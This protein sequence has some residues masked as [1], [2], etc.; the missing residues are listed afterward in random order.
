M[1]GSP[2]NIHSTRERAPRKE[3]ANNKGSRDKPNRFRSAS[4]NSGKWS[5]DDEEFIAS[6]SIQDESTFGDR[7]VPRPTTGRSQQAKTV[8][9]HQPQQQ[10]FFVTSPPTLRE[11]KRNELKNKETFDF[12]SPVS[13]PKPTTYRPIETRWNVNNV[14]THPTAVTT[15]ATEATVSVKYQDQPKNFNSEQDYSI[16]S[17]KDQDSISSII[18]NSQQRNN[19]D[20]FKVEQKSVNSPLFPP[21]ASI[22]Q[23]NSPASFSYFDF[24]SNSTPE[25]LIGGV[26][27][28]FVESDEQ[29]GKEAGSPGSVSSFIDNLH[30]KFSPFSQLDSFSAGYFSTPLTTVENTAERPITFKQA[31]KVREIESFSQDISPF[32]QS[33][34][35]ERSTFIPSPQIE[36][37]ND[38]LPSRYPEL[39]PPGRQLNFRSP[40]PTSTESIAPF[41]QPKFPEPYRFAGFLP[42]PLSGTGDSFSQF[43]KPNFPAFPPL[44]TKTI[45]FGGNANEPP[46]HLQ[47]NIVNFI[48]SKAVSEVDLKAPSTLA[49]GSGF[50]PGNFPKS[51]VPFKS[52]SNAQLG[53]QTQTNFAKQPA[54]KVNFQ[55]IRTTPPSNLVNLGPSPPKTNFPSAATNPTVS[56]KNEKQTVPINNVRTPPRQQPSSAA[57]H[58]EISKIPGTTPKPY[59]PLSTAKPSRFV[60]SPLLYT[61]PIIP[62][63]QMPLARPV[64][65]PQQFSQQVH[66]PQHSPTGK[67]PPQPAPGS[68]S[69]WNNDFNPFTPIV[70]PVG[71]RESSGSFTPPRNQSPSISPQIRQILP[72]LTKNPAPVPILAPVPVYLRPSSV[73]VPQAPLSKTYSIPLEKPVYYH[74]FVSYG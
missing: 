24:G 43:P 74:A 39:K 56:Q 42:R 70:R 44:S 40:L 30:T 10:Q 60:A 1:E 51:F 16:K 12:F 52:L 62:A 41:S 61:K 37:I 69:K 71:T 11:E 17:N 13:E 26:P 47:N 36:L 50:Y 6:S 58:T 34:S 5:S 54:S 23:S 59:T 64:R 55:T 33:V 21:P 66:P 48:K 32:I 35:T 15:E 38:F 2:S 46:S 27:S 25:K 57:P 14:N 7:I 49:D 8:R 53:L 29:A 68:Y 73:T 65:V 4:S 45:Y 9:S 28:P 19:N 67:A 20:G 72:S 63:N 31:S 22:S 18:S 3:S